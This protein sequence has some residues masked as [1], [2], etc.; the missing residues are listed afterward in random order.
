MHL[1]IIWQRFLPYHIAR[2][3]HLNQRCIELGWTLTAIEVASQDD[4]YGFDEL[5]DHSTFGLNRV[6]CFP[7]ASYH[8]HTVDEI[9]NKVYDALSA[10]K[11]DVVFAPATPFPEGM[12][13]IHYRNK[14]GI[15]CVMMDDAWECSDL[16]HGITRHIKKSIHKSVDAVFVPARSHERYFMSMGFPRKRIFFGVD[17]VDNEMF[18]AQACDARFQSDEWRKQLNLPVNYFLFVGRFLPRKGLESMVDAYR[19]YRQQVKGTPWSLVLVGDGEYL[20]HIRTMAD[21]I[22]GILFSGRQH[23]DA[24]GAYYGLA[25]ALVVPSLIDPWGLVVNEGMASGLPVLVSKGCGSAATLVN[26]GENGW[27]FNPGDSIGLAKRMIELSA[28]PEASRLRL[29]AHS[30]DI[31]ADWSLDR[32]ASGAIEAAGVCRRSFSG[33]VSWLLARLWKGKVTVN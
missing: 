13:A 19:Q 2:I 8:T 3:R 1:A 30:R 18:S 12:S 4:T 27:I 16:K 33:P 21:G 28:L 24:L 17:V 11:P 15:K 23:G 6:C 7:S 22:D 31:I 9:H 29:G 20:T 26:D 25:N 14:H 5:V 10:I 32:F